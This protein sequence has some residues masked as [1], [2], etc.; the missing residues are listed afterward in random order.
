V[1]FFNM[2][3]STKAR[4]NVLA[5]S[6]DEPL[7]ILLE[8]THPELSIP[9]RIVNNTEKITSN[10]NEFIP[11][12]FDFTMPDDAG[13]Q[14]PQA[15]LSIDNIGRE[16][17]QWLEYSNGGTG[18]QCRAMVV[19]PSEPNNRQLDITMDMSGISITNTKVTATLGYGN[20]YGLPAVAVRY[21]PTSTPGAF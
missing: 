8:I 9:V 6:A 7:L 15:K 20:S 16:L 21:D 14:L 18:A 13:D 4:Q 17:T 5:T 11:C 3:L 19:L 1:G 2:S 12:P 10:G